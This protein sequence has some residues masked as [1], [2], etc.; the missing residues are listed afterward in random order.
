LLSPHQSHDVDPRICQFTKDRQRCQQVRPLDGVGRLGRDRLRGMRPRVVGSRPNPSTDLNLT[1]REERRCSS[2]GLERCQVLPAFLQGQM[3]KSA[4][5]H[6]N[7]EQSV[8]V[9]SH[10]PHCPRPMCLSHRLFTPFGG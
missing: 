10:N 1:S 9:A 3:F 7:F 4:P 6:M 2:R 8:A 5:Y